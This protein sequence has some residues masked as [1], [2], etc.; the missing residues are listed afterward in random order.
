MNI[1]DVHFDLKNLFATIEFNGIKKHEKI[2]IT[3]THIWWDMASIS[4]HFDDNYKSQK[5]WVFIWEIWNKHEQFIKIQ[6]YT[7]EQNKN[8][9]ITIASWSYIS[10]PHK[11]T[12]QNNKIYRNSYKYYKL[13]NYKINVKVTGSSYGDIDT[14]NC[15][16]DGYFY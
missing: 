12:I 9:W 16:D 10:K 15:N 2:N 3:S 1:I 11:G 13:T 5:K 6:E 8:P 14:N 7:K 4:W